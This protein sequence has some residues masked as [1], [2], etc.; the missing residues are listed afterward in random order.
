VSA[1][2]LCQLKE[3]GN[4]PIGES[5]EPLL[6]DPLQAG[7]EVMT[8]NYII[9]ILY[10]YMCLIDIQMVI[11]VRSSIKGSFVGILTFLGQ[12]VSIIALL[13]GVEKEAKDPL[14]KE[15]SIRSCRRPGMAYLNHQRRSTMLG[16]LL[17]PLGTGRSEG[18]CST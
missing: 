4:A 17:P 7:R 6:W 14:S 8:A 10:L 11:R 15:R 1:E 16:M 13:N 2:Q 3:G 12:G 9:D 18:G 5:I